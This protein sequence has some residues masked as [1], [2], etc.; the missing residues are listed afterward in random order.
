MEE[1]LEAVFSVRSVPRRYKESALSL[2]LVWSWQL[3]E[4]VVSL[5]G[6]E[7]GIRGTSA[8]KSRSQ[9]T[10]VKTVKG[11]LCYSEL[12]SAVTSR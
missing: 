12:L 8:V 10:L 9:A 4:L 5:R 3:E 6:R 7:P 2:Q 11:G 1:L